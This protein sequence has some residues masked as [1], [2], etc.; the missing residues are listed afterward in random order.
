V[1]VL[2]APAGIFLFH[3]FISSSVFFFNFP[4]SFKGKFLKLKIF[5]FWVFLFRSPRHLYQTCFIGKEK[6]KLNNQ[7]FLTVA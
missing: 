3:I 6:K 7:K 5:F 1:T 2:G 4:P